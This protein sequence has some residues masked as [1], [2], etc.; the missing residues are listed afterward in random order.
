MDPKLD[1]DA[2]LRQGGDMP[3]GGARIEVGRGSSNEICLASMG[4]SRRHCCIDRRGDSIT[5]TD[6]GSHN[7]TYV[8]GVPVKERALQHGDE[9]RIGDSV[10]LVLLHEVDPL[11]A[12][13]PVE[14]KEQ[15]MVTGHT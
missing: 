2:G 5:L 13:A 12:G 1:D 9:V 7:G 15:G 10:F 11:P 4:V 8:N 14:L 3:L 6:L